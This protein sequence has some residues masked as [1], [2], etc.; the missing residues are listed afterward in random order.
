MKK[1][2][3]KHRLNNAVNAFFDETPEAFGETDLAA[4]GDAA[5]LKPEI[6]AQIEEKGERLIKI[7]KRGFL[8]FPGALYLFFGT[9]TVLSFEFLRNPVSALIVF[10]I[11]GFLTIFGLGSLKNPKHLAIPLSIVLVG[12]AAFFGF[13]AIGGL[14]YVFEHGVYLFP[15]ALVAPVLL[16]SL[17]DNEK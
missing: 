3:I 6:A 11:G 15:L 2:K 1:T 12:A 16:K 7:L 13:S 9:L 17:I 8:F 14:K 10:L 5:L 4:V